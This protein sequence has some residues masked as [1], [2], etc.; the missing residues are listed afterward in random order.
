MCINDWKFSNQSLSNQEFKEV[1]TSP[2]GQDL[3][4]DISTVGGQESFLL[5]ESDSFSASFWRVKFPQLFVSSCFGS[6]A[7]RRITANRTFIFPPKKISVADSETEL[8][9]DFVFFI[10]ICFCHYTV[11]YDF[12][13]PNPLCSR[14]RP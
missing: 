2:V 8:N 6:L 3:R 13:T 4:F 14:T 9:P 5:S 7:T 12:I 11:Q 10:F 1:M